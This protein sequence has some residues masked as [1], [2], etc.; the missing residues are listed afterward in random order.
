MLLQHVLPRYFWRS[1]GEALS[2]APQEDTKPPSATA[3]GLG[4]FLGLP[5]SR[6]NPTGL[7]RFNPNW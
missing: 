7:F 3:D 6:R 5:V 4:V 2:T 1:K